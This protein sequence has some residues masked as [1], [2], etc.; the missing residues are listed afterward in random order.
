MKLLIALLLIG[1]SFSACQGQVP[2]LKAVMARYDQTKLAHDESL[3]EKY[4]MELANLRW[5]LTQQGKEGWEDI[6]EEVR[7]HP[8][9]PDTADFLK[10]RPGKWISSRHDYLFKADG[11]WVMNDDPNANATHGTWAIKGNLYTDTV[12][13][14][15][16]YIPKGAYRIILLDANNFIYAGSDRT[17]YERRPGTGGWPL[18]RDDPAVK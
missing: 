5:S 3:R 4:V 14:K 7:H 12:A 8:A 9:P 18:R 10:A 15:T 2:E 11:T 17:Y 6:D 1:L 13:A 16:M